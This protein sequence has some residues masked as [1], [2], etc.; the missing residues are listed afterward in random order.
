MINES[1]LNLRDV[2]LDKTLE[3]ISSEGFFIIFGLWVS[4]YWP[5][6]HIFITIGC[7]ILFIKDPHDKKLAFVPIARRYILCEMAS[8]SGGWF[9]LNY[10]PIIGVISRTVLYVKLAKKYGRSVVFGII[11]GLLPGIMLCLMAILF[12]PKKVKKFEKSWNVATSV[13]EMRARQ[14]QMR[15][16]EE[17]LL[18]EYEARREAEREEEQKRLEEERNKPVEITA[19]EY[20]EILREESRKEAQEK[21]KREEVD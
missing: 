7:L 20:L 13:D 16:E 6:R 3:L 19:S 18:A 10:L 11:G 4:L 21:R 17:I 12:N 14:I 2:L 1:I 9:I 15:K 8:G 5:I